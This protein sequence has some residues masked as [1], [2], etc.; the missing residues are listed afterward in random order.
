MII[1]LKPKNLVYHSKFLQF[2][3]MTSANHSILDVTTYD[4]KWKLLN[5]KDIWMSSDHDVKIRGLRPLQTPT[6]RVWERESEGNWS[7]PPLKKFWKKDLLDP[8]WAVPFVIQKAIGVV[9]HFPKWGVLWWGLRT[10]VSEENQWLRNL[11]RFDMKG[12]SI[13]KVV[14]TTD[15]FA[16]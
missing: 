10:V 1:I 11:E 14:R 7:I 4:E 6:Y 3:G 2:G 9:E 13:W 12:G 8:Y 15:W 5:R 16:L